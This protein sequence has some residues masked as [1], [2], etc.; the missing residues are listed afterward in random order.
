MPVP[1]GKAP[2]CFHAHAGG[3][4][5]CITCSKPTRSHKLVAR[6]PMQNGDFYETPVVVT[7]QEGCPDCGATVT[8]RQQAV[9][10]HS[11]FEKA[12]AEKKAK[13]AH[14]A[15]VETPS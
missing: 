12:E 5:H 10:C 15:P 13:E 8:V 11:C 7:T 14:D 2:P 3:L 1:S 6:V 4:G 9:Q